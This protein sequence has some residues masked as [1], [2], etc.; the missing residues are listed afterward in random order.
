MEDA[1]R[2]AWSE[3]AAHV[4]VIAANMLLRLRPSSA[5]L[6][7]PN[8]LVSW[9]QMFYN[10][11]KFSEI[12]DQ[13]NQLGILQSSGNARQLQE[14]DVKDLDQTLR[15]A[16]AALENGLAPPSAPVSICPIKIVLRSSLEGE[17]IVFGL[18]PVISVKSA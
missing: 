17:T 7:F 1:A 9:S 11:H 13:F 10:C 8:P 18:I 16:A 14:R 5:G 12:F 2:S 3:R 15:A 6:P 4:V